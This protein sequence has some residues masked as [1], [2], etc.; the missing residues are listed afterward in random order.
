MRN[1]MA[2]ERPSNGQS[3]VPIHPEIIRQGV[4][5][6]IRDGRGPKPGE[7][8]E[9]P[10]EEIAMLGLEAIGQAQ[11]DAYDERMM[12]AMHDMNVADLLAAPWP[13]MPSLDGTIFDDDAELL[14]MVAEHD[15][16]GESLEPPDEYQRVV[17]EFYGKP[18]EKKN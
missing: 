9:V 4:E 18:S 10:A 1:G 8:V 16:Q 5:K 7:S 3:S 11:M 17:E 6:F 2:E 12:D 13:Q 14:G 15:G